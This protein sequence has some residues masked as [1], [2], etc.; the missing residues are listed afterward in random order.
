VPIIGAQGAHV[1]LLGFVYPSRLDDGQR[2]CR[3]VVVN[4]P[5]ARHYLQA[6]CVLAE[7]DAQLAA[8]RPAAYSP[9][10]PDAFHRNHAAGTGG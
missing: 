9:G 4:H 6:N 2:L 10:V 3:F 1:V 7:V 8:A 5:N